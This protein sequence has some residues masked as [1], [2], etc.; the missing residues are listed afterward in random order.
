[1]NPEPLDLPAARA[2]AMRVAQLLVARGSKNDAVEVLTV[3]AAARNDADGHK[4]LAEALRYSSDSPLA[5]AAFASMEGLAGEQPL[6]ENA[7]AKWT[8]EALARFEEATKKPA[9][10]WQTEVGYNNNVRYK[11]QVFHI[12]TEDSGVKRPHIITHLFADGGRILKSYKR[13]YAHLIG[14]DKLSEQV[15]ALMKGQHKEMYIALRE[16]KFDDI[17]E[18]RVPGGMEVFESPPN[19]D[20]R[21]RLASRPGSDAAAEAAGAAPDT[22]PPPGSAPQGPPATIPA[23]KPA[24]L[25]IPTLPLPGAPGR[26]V[27][28]NVAALPRL[29]RAR[30]HVI[31]A[32]RDSGTLLHEITSDTAALGGAGDVVIDDAFV[33][34]RQALLKFRSGRLYVEET[35]APNGVF[36]RIRRPVELDYG[37]VFIAG[38]QVLRVDPTPAPNDGPDAS[39][40]YFYSSPKW[41]STFR[42]VQLWEGGVPGACCVA[43]TNAVQIGRTAGDLSFPNDYWLSDSHCIVEDQGGFLMLTDLSS[44]AGTFVRIRGSVR[45]STGDE[46]L[47]G[48]TRLR[49][50]VLERQGSL[51]PRRAAPPG[52]ARAQGK[53]EARSLWVGALSPCWA[54]TDQP[55]SSDLS[56]EAAA[57]GAGVS[58]RA[59]FGHSDSESPPADESAFCFGSPSSPQAARAAAPRAAETTRRSAASERAFMG[60]ARL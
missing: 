29:V 15:R 51:G 52:A 25:G 11:E 21:R 39:P 34:E 10:G 27:G 5:K 18:G 37:D 26:K 58:P 35:G 6:L 20:A 41:A 48:R 24:A 7:R 53:P 22:A 30:L 42:V 44:R 1:M 40:T 32:M 43:R 13:V 2:S 57:V 17:I 59:P 16:G 45:I 38:E 12:Q 60:R 9:A 28:E 31:R 33:G 19:V 4:L 55:F 49:V 54:W 36:L 8:A 14:T 47:V 46:L 50:E 56:P 23:I 3:W